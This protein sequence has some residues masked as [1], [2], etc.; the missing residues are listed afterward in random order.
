[1]GKARYAWVTVAPLAW[2]V[3]VTMTAGWQKIFSAD[4]KLG[5][6]SHAG[7]ISAQV[8]SGTIPPGVQSLTDAGRLVRNDYIDAAVAAFFLISVIVVLVASAYEWFA[9][10]TG[11]KAVRTTEIPFIETTR[12]A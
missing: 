12:A 8:S 3:T 10:L 6:L 9:V 11:R 1:M 4:P 2:L 7:V 5:F